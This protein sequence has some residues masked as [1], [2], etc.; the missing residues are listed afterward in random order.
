MSASAM[1]SACF[2]P[3]Q[4]ISHFLRSAKSGHLVDRGRVGV[5]DVDG[6]L[7]RARHELAAARGDAGGVE[8]RERRLRDQ[9]QR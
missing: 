7:E 6:L 8:L 2:T 5:L 1:C 9:R 4:K 3:A